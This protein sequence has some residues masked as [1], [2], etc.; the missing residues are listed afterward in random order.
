MAEAAEAHPGAV[1]LADVRD[2]HLDLLEEWSP[3][4]AEALAPAAEA[5][6]VD[7]QA[8]GGWV[9]EPDERD[10]AQGIVDYWTAALTGL[11][12]RPFPEI[13]R[14][15]PFDPSLPA[16]EVARAEE[17]LAPLAGTP[18]QTEVEQMLLC[19]V[20]PGPHGAL[21]CRA[22]VERAELVAAG[23][24]GAGSADP[25]RKAELLDRLVAA[26]ILRAS[27]EAAGGEPRYAFAH[28]SAARA[29]DRVR[30]LV[31]QS[32]SMHANI[33]RLRATAQLWKQSGDA[34]FLLFGDALDDAGKYLGH[35]DT[36][37]AFIAASRRAA[38]RRRKQWLIFSLAMLLVVVGAT[39][40]AFKVGN[41]FGAEEGFVEGN[42][43]GFSK[44]TEIGFDRAVV[45]QQEVARAD[46][47]PPEAEPT[48]VAGGRQL[49]GW[50]WAGSESQ[51]Q[52]RHFESN[53]PVIPSELMPGQA[54]R[55]GTFL[56]LR[57]GPPG[58]DGD[59]DRVSVV[60]AGG[61]VLVRAPRT[62]VQRRAGIQYWVEVSF[63]PAVQVHYA[64]AGARQVGTLRRALI[65]AG[66]E[67]PPAAPSPDARNLREVRYFRPE[68]REMAALLAQRL[69]S[70]ISGADGAPLPISCVRDKGD[71]EA[72]R[73][74]IWLDFEG[75]RATPARAVPLPECS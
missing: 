67:V 2:R 27:N 65:E 14:L 57:A 36:L 21:I 54:Y 60:P 42:T 40:V 58:P 70:R 49:V 39:A 13:L 56:W 35:D 50:I 53:S 22:P 74:E 46:A 66:F 26:G 33:N 25:A 68:H 23:T 17:I 4:R 5:L 19:L 43:T 3:E 72:V 71:F 32:R 55:A 7:A 10:R 69:S 9:D 59:A 52:L 44:G 12:G 11:Q 6:R 64:N 30:T 18:L 73:L 24:D 48:L 1:S 38:E 15:A 75:I 51:P 34:G 61:R 31:D 45:T 47:P 29:W 20:R 28:G 16:G 63:V 62:T 37:N 8:L 41:W